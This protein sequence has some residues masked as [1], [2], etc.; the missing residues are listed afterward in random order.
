ML[1]GVEVSKEARA[2]A[3]RLLARR[4]RCSGRDVRQRFLRTYSTSACSSIS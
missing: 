2:A 1:G 4:Q 3:Q